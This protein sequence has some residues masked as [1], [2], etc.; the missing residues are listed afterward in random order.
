MGPTETS[1]YR[2]EWKRWTRRPHVTWKKGDSVCFG[3]ERRD[4]WLAFLLWGNN[5]SEI[6]T[7]KW[8]YDRLYFAG[9]ERDVAGSCWNWH[10]NLSVEFSDSSSRFCVSSLPF[11][12]RAATPQ[13]AKSSETQ[14]LSVICLQNG[15]PKS[16]GILFS[17]VLLSRW[18]WEP[19]RGSARN[20]SGFSSKK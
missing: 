3:T 18:Q 6:I 10:S 12:K 1:S 8:P 15:V 13:S 14:M 2:S 20:Q 9:C 5:V 4:Q 16:N 11:V 7:N 19:S 17:E